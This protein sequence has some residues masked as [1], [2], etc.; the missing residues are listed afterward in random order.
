MNIKEAQEE[1]CHTIKAYTAKNSAGLYRIPME[2]R[3]PLL[4]MGAPGIGKTAVVKQAAAKCHVAFLSYAMTH[5]TRQSAIGLPVIRERSFQGAP[6]SITEYTMSEIVGDILHIMEETGMEEGVLFLDEINCVSE[7]LLPTM[8]RLLQFKTFGSHKIP[9]GWLIVAA[10]NPPGY[11]RAARELDI[12][13]LDRVRLL[14]LE[15]DLNAW[16]PYAL[17]HGIHASIL[18][19]LSLRPEDFCVYRRR[20]GKK[21]FVTPR[22]WED[23]SKALE[24]YEALSLPVHEEFF[25]QY[26]QCSEI[27]EGFSS[28]Y[29]LF[30]RLAGDAGLEAL[31]GRGQIPEGFPSLKNAPADEQLCLAQYLVQNIYRQIHGWNEKRQLS[32]S[33]SYFVGGLKALRPDFCSIEERCLELLTKRKAA[34]QKRKE[35]GLLPAEE[36]ARELLLADTVKLFA[37]KTRLL[38]TNLDNPSNRAGCHLETDGTSPQLPENAAAAMEQFSTSFHSETAAEAVR[39]EAVLRGVLAFVPEI[40][41]DGLTCCLFFTELTEYSETRTFLSERMAKEYARCLEWT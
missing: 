15:P 39:L 28:F 21:E 26:L 20:E 5:H 12:V 35:F 23:L 38:G 19:Y 8:L 6:Y 9:D 24:T 1:I 32:E 41:G 30:L 34:L 16:H 25:P 33:L 17:E 27:C 40:F 7:T 3:R 13:T 11:N 10:G 22:S 37:S 14:T 29:Q 2:H 18:A 31:T 4:L 36:E